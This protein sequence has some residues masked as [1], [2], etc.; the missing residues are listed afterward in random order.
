[1]GKW[2]WSFGGN[3]D[4]Y[5]AIRFVP[6]LKYIY[7]FGSTRY[8][9]DQGGQKGFSEINQNKNTKKYHKRNIS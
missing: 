8:G 4:R 5:E 3:S 6:H 1:M 2:K 7:A 9:V